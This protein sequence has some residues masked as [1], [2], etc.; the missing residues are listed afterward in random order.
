MLLWK[1]T[2]AIS[3]GDEST[4]AGREAFRAERAS[5]GRAAAEGMPMSLLR[6][7]GV[8]SL[9]P[10]VVGELIAGD[11]L[12]ESFNHRGGAACDRVHY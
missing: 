8:E 10:G 5:A 3:L 11:E 7:S 4:T 6:F 12:L 9:E 1:G 2:Q